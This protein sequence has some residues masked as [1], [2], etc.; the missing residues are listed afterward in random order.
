MKVPKYHRQKTRG[1]ATHKQAPKAFLFPLRRSAPVRF[2]FSLRSKCWFACKTQWK[3]KYLTTDLGSIF[4]PNVGAVLGHA[5]CL[6]RTLTG[7]GGR[8]PLSLLPIWHPN[9]HCRNFW[10]AS[11]TKQ[12]VCVD[13]YVADAHLENL[14]KCDSN[15]KHAFSFVAPNT[16]SRPICFPY[17]ILARNN[18]RTNETLPYIFLLFVFLLAAVMRV[19]KSTQDVRNGVDRGPKRNLKR[20]IRNYTGNI[21]AQ[22]GPYSNRSVGR[23]SAK[24][25]KQ[26]ASA[27]TVWFSKYLGKSGWFPVLC[28]PYV[29][30][31]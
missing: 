10:W 29:V 13:E 11:T 26:T 1:P 5:C 4:G 23:T 12:I 30:F 20:L 8:R 18:R 14:N 15:W 19:S 17:V 21:K 28:S 22:R 25:T 16:L 2:L 9:T 3:T 7:G 31:D 6:Y 24:K 27:Q